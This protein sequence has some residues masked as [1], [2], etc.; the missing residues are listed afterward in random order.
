MLHVSGISLFR[1]MA[2]RLLKKA[3]ACTAF[4]LL[5]LGIR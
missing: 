4:Q 2:S 3:L 5:C 1:P